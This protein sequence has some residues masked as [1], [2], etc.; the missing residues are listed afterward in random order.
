MQQHRVQQGDKLYIE[1]NLLR[2]AGALFCHD[3]KLARTRT[4]EIRLHPDAL[5][6]HIVVRPDP[7][8]GQPGP[9]AHKIFVALIKKHSDYGK[10]IRNEIHFTR[11]EIGRLIGRKEWGGRDSEQLSRA[12]HEIHHAFVP[13]NFKHGDARSLEHS[14]AIFPEILIERREFASDPI[15]TCTVTLAEPIVRSLQEEHFVCLNHALMQQLGTIGQALYMRCFFHFANHYTGVNRSRLM[16][17]KRYGDICSEWLGG[18]SVCAHKS[19]IERDQLGPHLRQLISVGVL[20]SYEISKAKTHGGFIISFKPGAAFFTDYERFYRRRAHGELQWELRA[21][22]RAVG[23]PLKLAY[24]FAEKRTG[25]PVNSVAYVNSKDVETSKQLLT[26][27]TLDEA[28]AFIDIAL[29]E[30]AKTNFDVHTLGGLRQYLAAFKARK[31]ATAAAAERDAA[32]RRQEEQQLAYDAYRR[33]ELFYK[34][35]SL[36]DSEQGQIEAF[37]RACA[38]RFGGAADG[39]LFIAMK[40]KVLTERF[41]TRIKTYDEWAACG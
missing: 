29:A 4:A 7:K 31:A 1:S 19:V 22:E 13:T 35:D 17:Q 11:R 5:D 2:I 32:V 12:L 26:E 14:F 20:S 21:D 9:L 3:Q 37:A 15:E 41:G 28:P 40:V 38:T 24:L 36:P 10:P 33:K 34:F 8:F 16:F 18:L 30:A 23:E 39:P 6:K 27:L 25:Q